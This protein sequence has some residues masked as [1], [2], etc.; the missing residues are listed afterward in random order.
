MSNKSEQIKIVLSS[1]VK[2]KLQEEAEE[3]GLKLA[4]YVSWLLS[5]ERRSGGRMSRRDLKRLT[6]IF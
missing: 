1:E 4:T 5:R 3:M 2:K 6:D